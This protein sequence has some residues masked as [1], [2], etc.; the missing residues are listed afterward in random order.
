[1]FVCFKSLA[2]CNVLETTGKQHCLPS[3]FQVFFFFF[4]QDRVLY[5]EVDTFVNLILLLIDPY[6]LLF[7]GCNSS[8]YFWHINGKWGF[9]TKEAVVMWKQD[10]FIL[11]G[12]QQ[13][14]VRNS[15][16]MKVKW[17]NIY[18]ESLLNIHQTHRIKKT[19]LKEIYTESP[20]QTLWSP[21]SNFLS[22]N[23]F[24][25]L[26]IIKNLK[27]LMGYITL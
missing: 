22:Q 16:W 26:K 21:F 3:Q 10:P 8:H 13:W 20:W 5:R 19:V 23:T 1:M 4:N 14:A 25:L 11:S 17:L 15:D 12:L 24:T 18:W 7:N 9:R 2:F 27:Q 6:T